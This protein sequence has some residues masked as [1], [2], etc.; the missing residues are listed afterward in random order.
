MLWIKYFSSQVESSNKGGNKIAFD[1]TKYIWV[2]LPLSLTPIQSG[3][4]FGYGWIFVIL[5]VDVASHIHHP[6]TS[7]SH[8][9]TNSVTTNLRI[10]F[11]KCSLFYFTRQKFS[12]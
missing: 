10:F 6:T 1:D 7:P 5:T 3:I 8:V 11:M 2:L 4:H 9:F 12:K